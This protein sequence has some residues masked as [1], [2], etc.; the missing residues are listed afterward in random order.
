LFGRISCHLACDKLSCIFAGLQGFLGPRKKARKEKRLADEGRADLPLLPL[1]VIDEEK[2]AATLPKKGKRK[3]VVPTGDGPLDSKK[4]KQ[5]KSAKAGGLNIRS[6]KPIL[7]ER[8]NDRGVYQV[9]LTGR[10]L[11]ESDEGFL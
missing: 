4:K 2:G 7:V 9:H 1:G 11:A 5:K 6:P 8:L 10:S 3:A